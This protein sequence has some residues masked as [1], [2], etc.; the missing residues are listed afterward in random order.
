MVKQ[1]DG[2]W[3]LDLRNHAFAFLKFEKLFSGI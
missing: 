2:Y 3:K 1:M